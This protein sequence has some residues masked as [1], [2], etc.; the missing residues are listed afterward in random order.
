MKSV[1]PGYVPLLLFVMAVS[2]NA[3]AAPF[4]PPPAVSGTTPSGLPWLSVATGTAL[5]I[6]TSATNPL[7]GA[8]GAVVYVD[9]TTGEIQF[10]PK[11]L[12]VTTFI[13][14]YT[15][16][17]VNIASTTPGPFE[18][19]TGTGDFSYSDIAGTLRTFPA[20][21][22]T[23]S[24]L[25]PTT[26]ASRVGL[27]VGPPLSANLNVGTNPNSASTNNFWNLAWAF[28][29]DLVKSGSVSSLAANFVGTG[30]N[31]FRTIDQKLN[32]NV[33]ILGFGSRQSVFQYTASGITG[34]QVGAV[35]PVVSAPLVINITTGVQ[36]QSN[37]LSGRVPVIKTGAGTLILDQPNTL[38]GS[39]TVQGGRLR[40][41]H[42]TALSSSRIV[43]LVGG[44]LT[45]SGTLKTTVGGLD[46]NAGGLTDVSNGLITVAAGLSAADTLAAITK[47]R[48][49]GSW[50]GTS[51]MT[52]TQAAAD[53]VSGFSRAVG[54]V[55]NSNGSITVAYA[56]PGDTNLDWIVDILDISKFVSS[57]K[58]GTGQPAVWAEG[59][60][61]YDGVVDIQDVA[62][63]STT[64]LY[65]LGL[66]NDVPGP[67]AA[68]PEPA[69]C[70]M[71][72][73][74]IACGGF[75]MWRRR[76]RA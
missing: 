2:A 42:R 26:Y 1:V 65:G 62:D 57:G 33:N 55:E 60:F 48:S 45:L 13:L 46:P 44:T 53:N 70:A 28:P 11:G 56:A 63:F 14:T 10:D 72:L 4:L 31:Y 12:N 40:L 58:F 25:A 49:T 23:S 74:G 68:V 41:A 3:P 19:T 36:T 7:N 15:T 64:G 21:N 76:R 17:T 24:G 16:G 59:D 71:A 37:I 69:T 51:G 32:L 34:N 6:R 35:I 20:K 39:T 22:P 61:N 27:T 29:P 67:V 75:S 66:Y 18:Y 54:W 52:S 9:T 5:P 38:T 43:P 73:A 50:F 47:G 8:P 30:N